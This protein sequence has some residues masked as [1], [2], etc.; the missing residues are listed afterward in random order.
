MHIAI[1]FSKIFENIVFK[2]LIEF[3]ND[4]NILYE[5]QFGFRKHHSTSHALI[6]LVDRVTKSI[7]TVKYIVGVFLDL[8]K[9]FD[10]VDHSILLKKTGKYGLEA[11]YSN[12]SKVIYPVENN[13]LNTMIVILRKKHITHRVPQGSI[14]G[15]NM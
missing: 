9:A 10:T 14:L 3:L 8:K 7:D 4:N 6:A 12:G 15:L 5:Y 13:L 1:F 11:T 2:Y